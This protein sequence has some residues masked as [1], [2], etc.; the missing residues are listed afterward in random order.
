MKATRLL[1]K[2]YGEKSD[3][4]WSLIN[5]DF[6]LAAQADTIEEAQFLLESQIKD[7]ITDALHG[8]DREHAHGLLTRRAPVKYW[9]KWWV[10]VLRARL[11]GRTNSGQKAFC[12]PIPLVP[13]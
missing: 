9:I 10:G 5:L 6:C 3:G 1:L 4:Q 2:I 7:Y 11:G 8:Q 12:E 13:A